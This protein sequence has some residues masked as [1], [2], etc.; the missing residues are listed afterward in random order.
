[1]INIKQYV[2]VILL[3]VTILV[4]SGCATKYVAPEKEQTAAVTFTISVT[5]FYPSSA[6]VTAKAFEHGCKKSKD[7]DVL[8]NFWVGSNQNTQDVTIRA[9][10]IFIYTI[11]F[12]AEPTEYLAGSRCSISTAFFPEAGVRYQADFFALEKSCRSRLME[13]FSKDGTSIEM[14]PVKELPV[15][16][17]CY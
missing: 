16:G 6:T 3:S 8:A 11:D 13:R 7:G 17:T 14:R 2:K 4:I 1:M 12:E 15:A 9:G 10:K 5:T